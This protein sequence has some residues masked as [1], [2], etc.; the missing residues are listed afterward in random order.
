MT[1]RVDPPSL[2]TFST[3][4]RTGAGGH[5]DR[6]HGYLT[7]YASLTLEQQGFMGKVSGAHDRFARADGPG[8][9]WPGWN[10]LGC[11]WCGCA[12]PAGSGPTASRV[13][14]CSL[15]RV[16][17]RCGASGGST[18]CWPRCAGWWCTR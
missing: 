16:L 18:R 15:V 5:A 10:S 13:V 14:R 7:T 1:M 11:S 2:R 6:V 9:G 17:C 8:L 3:E 12:M 4:L